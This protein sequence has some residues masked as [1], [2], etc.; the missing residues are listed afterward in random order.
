MNDFLLSSTRHNITGYAT[1]GLL[2]S[3]TVYSIQNAGFEIELVRRTARSPWVTSICFLEKE[4][5]QL[6]A[7]IHYTQIPRPKYILLNT[8][9]GSNT[10]Q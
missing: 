9:D 1:F 3:P 4:Y 6:G 7:V 2:F 10:A 5:K 8:P